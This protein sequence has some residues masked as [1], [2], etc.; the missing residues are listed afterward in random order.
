MAQTPITTVPGYLS[1]QEE[2]VP[3]MFR[4]FRLIADSQH[5]SQAGRRDTVIATHHALGKEF[6]FGE[7]LWRIH[8]IIAVN[9]SSLV[10]LCVSH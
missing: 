8:Q 2:A 10:V 1:V 3:A 5:P 4:V 7:Q 9:A 6:A